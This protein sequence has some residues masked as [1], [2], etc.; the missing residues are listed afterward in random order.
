MFFIRGGEGELRHLKLEGVNLP[1]PHNQK[2][3]PNQKTKKNRPN[4]SDKKNNPPQRRGAVRWRSIGGEGGAH[5]LGCVGELWRTS[6]FF[7]RMKSEKRPIGASV[8]REK[9]GG[10]GIAVKGVP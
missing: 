4:K 9:E 2:P 3:P 5:R 1:I 8:K 6:G 7:S 10:R